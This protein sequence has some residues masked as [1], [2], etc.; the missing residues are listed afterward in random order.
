MASESES[1]QS[2]SADDVQA[3]KRLREAHARIL[4]ELRETIVGMDQVLDE[5]MIAVFSR[6]HCLLIGVPGL[7]K[8]CSSVRWRSVYRFHL[9]AFS[10]RQI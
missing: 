6:G 4:G 8:R 10:L 9:N 1:I 5:L 3:V 7:L 2:A